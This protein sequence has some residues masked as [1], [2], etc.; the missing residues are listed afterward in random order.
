MFLVLVSTINQRDGKAKYISPLNIDFLNFVWKQ[1][2][3]NRQLCDGNFCNVF[4]LYLSYWFTGTVMVHSA[5]QKQ[6]I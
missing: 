6:V 2:F 3:E 1:I 5:P 4:T